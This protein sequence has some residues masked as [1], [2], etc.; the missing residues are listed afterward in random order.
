M[1]DQRPKSIGI[2]GAGFTGTML[3]VHLLKLSREPIQVILF[4][5]AA[6]FSKGT[7]YATPNAKH[8]LNVR[9]LNM[10]AYDSD[11]AHF[12]RWLEHEEHRHTVPSPQQTFVSR[13]TYGRYLKSIL[14][15][16]RSTPAGVS[17]VSE[18]ENEVVG[19]RVGPASVQLSLAGNKTLDVDCAVLCVGNFPPALPVDAAL[20]P[21]DLSRYVTN[22]WDLV[23]LGRIDPLDS[24]VLIGTGLTMVDT[25][26]ELRSRGHRGSLMALSRRGFVPVR[27]EETAQYPAFLSSDRL[28][29]RISELVR[30][31]RSEVTKAARNGMDWR[32]VVDA[33][34]PQTQALWRNLPLE[35]RRRFLRHVRPYWEVHRHRLAPQVAAEIADLQD[36]KQLSVMAGRIMG[37][38]AGKQKL[39]MTVRLKV[40]GNIQHLESDWIVNCS[41]PQLDYSRIQDPLI[42][43]LFAAE[44]ARPD[45]LSLGID[46][47]D[48]YRLLDKSGMAATRLFALGPPIRGSLWETTAV[49]DIRKQCE[50]LA[51]ELVG[52]R[53]NDELEHGGSRR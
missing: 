43:S 18:V 45:S 33:M 17:S 44:L 12:I 2:V 27:H 15:V 29:G 48:D 1:S 3:A 37:I 40:G 10:S 51:R 34:R 11:P 47:T 49:P 28:P 38:E 14:D 25:V 52:A 5:R 35:E 50:A 16:A 41:G 36:S 42:K 32:S 23:A 46:V 30:V 8:L 21:K 26:L 6:A 24:V 7:V 19:V 53:A 31:V 13:G 4:D 39:S 20:M 22:P 9:V